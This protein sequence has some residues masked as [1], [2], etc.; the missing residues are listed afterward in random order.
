MRKGSWSAAVL[1]CLAM[2]SLPTAHAA[3]DSSL[4]GP[5]FTTHY[6]SDWQRVTEKHRGKTEYTLTAPG[7]T[8]K[9]LGLPSAP[10]GAA[11]TV[12]SWTTRAFRRDFHRRP[13]SRSGKLLDT[14]V[15]VPRDATDVEDAQRRRAVRLAGA[16][17]AAVGFRYRYKGRANLQ[18]DVVARHGPTVIFAE[19][20]MDPAIGDAGLAPWRTLRSTWRWR[21]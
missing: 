4:K 9:E 13:P 3:A 15:G 8:V 11:I 1:V 6:P 16:R 17:G 14:I 18:L 10:G 12:W 2:V 20:N 19:L 21:S 5:R 7:T